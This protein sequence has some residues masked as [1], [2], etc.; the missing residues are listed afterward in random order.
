MRLGISGVLTRTFIRSP[1]TPLLLLASLVVGVV[2]LLSLPREEEPQISVPMVDILVRA[3]GLKAGDAVELVTKPLE[4]IVKGIDGVE[5]TYSQTMDDGVVVTARFLVGTSA[6]DAILRVH[7]KVR[8]NLN[9]IPLGIPEPLIV[10]RGINDVAIL[11]LTLAPKP[12]EAERWT[13]TALHGVAEELLAQLVQVEDVGKSTVVG[14]RPDQIRVEPDPERLALFGVT[15]TQLVDKVR[16]ANRSFIVGSVRAQGGSLP[17]VAGQTLQGI[18]DIGLLLVTTRD[19]RPV[20]VKD[21][22]DVVVGSRPDESRA[23]TM[24]PDGRGGLRRAPAVT[25]SLAKRAG[26]NAVTIAGRVLERVGAIQATSLPKGLA[27]TVTRNYGETA[28]EKVNELLFHLALATVT[29]VALIVLAIGWREGVVTLI[30]IPT[31]IL[32]TMAASWLMG[33]TI[34]RVSLFALIFSIGILVD[35]AIVVVENIDRH[36]AM[37]DGR[38]KVQAAIEA[39]AEVGNPTIVATL[40]VIAALLPMMFVSGLMGPYMSPIPANASAAMLFSFF[41]A[42]VLTPWLMVKLRPGE[43]TAGEI[44]GGSDGTGHRDGG[45]LGRIYL[46]V[47]RPLIRNRWRAWIFLLAVGAATLASTALFYTKDVAV[48][49][50]PFDNKSELQVIVDLPRGASLEDTERVLLG[51]ADAIAGLQELDSVQAYGGTASPFNFNGLVRH[52]YLRDQPEQGDLQVNLAPKGK[53]SR[54]S[55]EIALDVRARLKRLAVPKGTTIKVVEV[56]PGPPVL[57]TLLVEVYGP[58][59]E[60]RNRTAHIVEDA[61]RGVDFIVDVDTTVR[62]P[63]ERL[64][65]ALDHESLEFHGVEEQAVYDTLQALIGGVPVGYSHRGTG[66]NPIEIAVQLPKSG[67]FLSERILATPVPGARGTVELGDLVTMTREPASHPLFRRNGRFAEMV[68]ADLAGRFEA[69]VYGMLAVQDRLME[70]DWK[71]VGLGAAPDILLHGQ[72]DDQSRPAL[73]WDG[74]WEITYVTFRDMGAAFAVA[75]LGIYLLV[76]GQFGSFKLPLVILV[77]V[78]LTLIGILFGHWLFGAGLT[79]TSMIGFIALAG[80]IVRNSI[81]L[82]D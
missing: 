82:L 72:P 78:P 36:W 44:G 63:G 57:S 12:E 60:T 75:I 19:G 80:I 7:E 50:L 58:D 35:D 3:D 34:N 22:A 11:T 64:R 8:A 54:G 67:L 59:V 81:L 17:V 28:N 48:K 4:E 39:V 14:G 27:L 10:G 37:R 42:M 15:L 76:V 70:I 47:A 23:W 43:A 25:I 21:V 9:R 32:L 46:A 62:P 38:S 13:D 5:H 1:L 49:L 29:I 18:A 74:E 24:T 71:A 20:Y 16:N 33:Y 45:L 53:R 40:T 77:P 41:V 66:R 2:A 55:H 69:P 52:Y 68:T 65:F 61:F 30:V 73:L 51:A 56:P 31:T 79:A 6:D 26:A